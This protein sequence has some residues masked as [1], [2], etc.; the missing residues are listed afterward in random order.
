MV[1]IGLNICLSF[2]TLGLFYFQSNNDS[3]AV[4]CIGPAVLILG[5]MLGV[6]VWS[7]S[8]TRQELLRDKKAT[9][10]LSPSEKE[11]YY[12]NKK[13]EKQSAAKI[14]AFGHTSPEMICPHC[15]TRGQIRT[16]KVTQDKG[17]SGGKATGAVLTGGLSV[18]ATGLSR[19][20]D[21]TQ[22]HCD[23]CNS[24]WHF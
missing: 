19:K 17:I 8:T 14:A 22:A 11:R 15:Q 9:A 21:V 18:L 2:Q 23:K 5:L 13:K 12:E 16:L 3:G 1:M 20:E 4:C 10:N 24:T 6:W 7:W